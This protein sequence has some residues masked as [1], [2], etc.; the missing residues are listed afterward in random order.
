[1]QNQVN[2]RKTGIRASEPQR[3][4]I[5]INQM[6]DN[7]KSRSLV[8]TVEAVQIVETVE[9]VQIVETVKIVNTSK[10]QKK[11]LSLAAAQRA[12]GGKTFWL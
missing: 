4:E 3:S 8:E 9:A 5:S 6:A 12:Q 7:S 2:G 10:R 1:M 11:T